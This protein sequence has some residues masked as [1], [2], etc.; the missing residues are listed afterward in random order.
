MLKKLCLFLLIFLSIFIISCG[1]DTPDNP[2]NPIVD[3][4]KEVIDPKI[5][6]LNT[7]KEIYIGDEIKLQAKIYPDDLS[8]EVTWSYANASPYAYHKIASIEGDVL[9]GLNYGS[10]YV[11]CE[12]NET[13]G[14]AAT[15]EIEVKHV[16][17]ENEDSSLKAW[18]IWGSPGED[19]SSMYNIHYMVKNTKSF[20][21]VTTEDDPEFLNARKVY[22]SGYYFEDIDK[23]I[24]SLWPERNVWDIVINEL[25][26]DTRYIYRINNGYDKYSDTFHFRTAGGTSSTSFLFLTDTHYASFTDGTDRSA[27]LSET[28]I[29]NAL[30]INPNISFILG[31]GDLIDTGGNENIWNIFFNSSKASRTALPYIVSTGNHELYVNGTGQRDS[32]HFGVYYPGSDNGCPSFNQSTSWFKHNDTLFVIMDNGKGITEYDQI[33]WAANVLETVEYKHSIFVFHTPVNGGD[34]TNQNYIDLFDTYGVDLVLTGHTHGQ[35]YYPYYYNGKKVEDQSYGTTY[36]TGAYSG[37]KSAKSYD[38]AI[39]TARNY[40]FDITDEGINWQLMFSNGELSTKWSLKFNNQAEKA[41]ATNQELFDSIKDEF[42]EETNTLNLTWSNKFYRNIKKITASENYYY[43]ISK[44]AVCPTPAYT[45]M[46][47]SGLTYGKIYT[48]DVKVEFAD[49]EILSKQITIDRSPELSIN[50]S[51]IL[52]DMA[53]IEFGY[54]GDEL[55]YDVKFFKIYLNDELKTSLPGLANTKQS[56]LYCFENLVENTNYKVRIDVV[57]YDDKIMF[58]KEFSFKTE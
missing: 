38:D 26:E 15:F 12:S 17:L 31:A 39:N 34:W 24:E 11:T 7:E 52:S 23:T 56:N 18:N 37:V 29:K 54:I 1:E 14:L 27:A 21:E 42:D 13:K 36:F 57:D 58:S 19:A 48:I 2:D 20:A 6:I 32:K 10:I 41:P 3:P 53:E 25:K 40:I 4:P 47:L 8:Q 44:Y 49:G 45:S 16:L 5:E 35:S 30:Q 55:K 9:K 28:A 46:S 43:N 33:K 50:E 22:G 51:F